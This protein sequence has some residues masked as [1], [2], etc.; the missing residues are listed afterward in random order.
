MLHVAFSLPFNR[1]FFIA[2]RVD[3]AFPV[4]SLRLDS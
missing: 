2:F 3:A 4:D 1:F